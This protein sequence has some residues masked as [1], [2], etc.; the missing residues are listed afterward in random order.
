MVPTNTEVFF[1]RFMTMREKQIL[2]RD[3]EIQKENW[4]TNILQ[5]SKIQSNVW[6]LFPNRSSIISEKCMVTPNF[7]F[8]YQKHLL[9]SASPYSFKPRKISLY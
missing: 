4:G 7:I 9:S 8:G 2:A 6:R 3:I 1:S 5:S